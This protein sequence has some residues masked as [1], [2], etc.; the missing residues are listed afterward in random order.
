MYSNSCGIQNHKIKVDL[1]L[2]KYLQNQNGNTEIFNHKC[3]V[4]RH[5]YLPINSDFSF[6]LKNSKN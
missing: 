6:I 3:L 5:N 2:I 4:T 1:A